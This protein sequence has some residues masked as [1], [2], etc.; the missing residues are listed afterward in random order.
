MSW[1]STPIYHPGSKEWA[2][3]TAT[4]AELASMDAEARA[5]RERRLAEQFVEDQIAVLTQNAVERFG[6]GMGTLLGQG[7]SDGALSLDEFMGL[8]PPLHRRIIYA[9]RLTVRRIAAYTSGLFNGQGDP[10]T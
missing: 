5:E 8:T 10:S 4:P 9:V 1:N 3:L 6:E 7:L 2:R